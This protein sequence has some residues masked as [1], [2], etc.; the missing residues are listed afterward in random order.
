MAPVVA[1][2]QA[3]MGSTRLPGK[4]LVDLGGKPMLE[5]VLA[6]LSRAQW[7]DEVVVATTHEARDDVLGRYHETAKAYGAT[8]VV[9]VTSDCPF[10]DPAIV[11]EVVETLTGTEGAHYA[12]N[13][14]TPRTYPRGLDCE[15]MTM[16]ALDA[17]HAKDSNPATREHVTP[18]IHRHP[19]FLLV[20]VRLDV[21]LS[22]YRWTVDTREDLAMARAAF[23]HFGHDRFTWRELLDACRHHPDW[24]AL[25]AN[26]TQK[27]VP[28]A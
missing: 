13:T 16:E 9:R 6:R 5:R 27:E 12:S 15:A 23:A 18:Y 21:D 20:P 11:D 1:I 8:I 19:A 25:N 26:V 22:R 10:L 4:A 2:V 3:R 7:V 24:M 14:L 28:G 17:A